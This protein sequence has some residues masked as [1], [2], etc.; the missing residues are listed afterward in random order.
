MNNNVIA[1]F[2]FIQILLN[3]GVAKIFN[4]IKQYIMD[5]KWICSLI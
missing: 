4:E 5:L 1:F 2:S 3:N